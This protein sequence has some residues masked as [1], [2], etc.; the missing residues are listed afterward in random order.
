MEKK[1]V[2]VRLENVTKRYK[3][4]KGKPDVIAVNNSNL[5]IQPGELITLLGPSGC[6]KTTTL[7]MVAGFELPTEGRIFIGEQDVT[8]LPPNKR[9]T[10]T[11]FHKSCRAGS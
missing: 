2:S 11:V 8:T 9:E 3:N 6:G 10:A 5:E 7:R 4:T 1:S